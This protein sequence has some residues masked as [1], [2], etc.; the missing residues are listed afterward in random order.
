MMAA[1]G[2]AVIQIPRHI[3]NRRRERPSSA[4]LLDKPFGAI[5]KLMS[6]NLRRR[7]FAC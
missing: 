4:L 6:V 7:S 1:G 3:C 2:A 5:K